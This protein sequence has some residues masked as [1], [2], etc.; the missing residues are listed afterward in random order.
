MKRQLADEIGDRAAAVR[1]ESEFGQGS[2]PG[3]MGCGSQGAG[4]QA[5]AKTS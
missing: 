4:A 3:K 5:P 2:G 1:S